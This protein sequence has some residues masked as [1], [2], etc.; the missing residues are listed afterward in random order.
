MELLLQKKPGMHKKVLAKRVPTSKPRKVPIGET[1]QFTIEQSDD[2]VAG[3]KKM[4]RA[5]STPAK[6]LGKSTMVRDSEEE[7]EEEDAA[8]APKSQKLMGVQLSL[9]LPLLSPRLPPML[10]LKLQRFQNPR[11]ALGTF[12]LQR[13]TRPQCLKL[14]KKMLKPMC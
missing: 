11:G 14:K 6:V 8:S 9:G 10:L 5:I 4:K 13:R 2:D 1:M 3:G 7:E 12:Q